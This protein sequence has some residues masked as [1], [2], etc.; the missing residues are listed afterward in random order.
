M[1]HEGDQAIIYTAHNSPEALKAE[2]ESSGR[3]PLCNATYGAWLG[4]GAQVVAVCR[5]SEEPVDVA[6]QLDNAIER[7]PHTDGL[8]SLLLRDDEVRFSS[9]F[10]ECSAP[11]YTPPALDMT[12]ALDINNKP[13]TYEV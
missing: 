3:Q 2:L 5:S 6:G 13:K 7:S 11:G 8:F 4:A 10:N 9:F 12:R 1:A